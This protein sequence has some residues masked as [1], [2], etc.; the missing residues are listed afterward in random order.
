MLA[1]LEASLR[2][3]L[4]YP[5]LFYLKRPRLGDPVRGG[6]HHLVVT[7]RPVVGGFAKSESKGDISAARNIFGHGK[8]FEVLRPIDEVRGN[9]LAFFHPG[10]EGGAF[11]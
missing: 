2:G 3:L 11:N 10:N 4:T 7:L 6:D 1:R 5:G 9:L 8:G